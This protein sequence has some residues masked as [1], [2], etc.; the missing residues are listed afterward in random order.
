MI[1]DDLIKIHDLMFERFGSQ[2]WWPGDSR[3]E[4]IVGAILTQNTNWANVEKAIANLTS[5]DSLTP[6]KLHHMDFEKLAS[7]IRPAGYYNIKARR[8]K[9]FLDWLFADYGGETDLLDRIGTSQL[10]NELLQIK[11]IGYE[12]ADS[13]LLYAFE[14][15]VFVVDTYTHRIMTRHGLVEP[16]ADYN[17]LQEL[18]QSN[19]P[20][21]VKM[22]NE[23]HALL[24]QVG[25]QFCRP[26]ARCENCPLN[27][28]SH[29]TEIE[30]F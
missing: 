29:Q 30:F 2:N 20:E 4:V 7:L 15:P 3:F 17:Q 27:S 18:F 12:T 1:N 10:R 8:L 22:F 21:D 11:G 6:A 28:H 9:N 23:Y 19:L 24:V 5:A 16:D 26:K 14:R 13:I 25:K